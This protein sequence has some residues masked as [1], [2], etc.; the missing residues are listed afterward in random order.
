[1]KQTLGIFFLFLWSLAAIA[2]ENSVTG[3]VTDAND[4]SP[5]P[6][7][8]VSIKGTTTGSVTSLDGVY[9]VTA[10]QGDVLVF[11]FIGMKTIEATVS[12][13]TLNAAMTSS[14]TDLDD[15]VV[16]GYGV[17]KKSLITGATSSVSA[18]EMT[19][20]TMRA[21]QALQGKAPGVSVTANSGSPGNG[22]KVRIR[23]AGSNGKADPLY[24]VDGMKTG[25]IN[26]LAPGDIESME[27]LK[28][29]ASSAIYGTEGANGVI[30]IKTK[31]GQKG[32]GRIDYNFQY[33]IQSMPKTMDMMNASQYASYM[34]EILDKDGNKLPGVPALTSNEGT[35]WLDEVGET[36]PMSSHHLSFSGGTDKSTYSI[37][38][39]YDSQ[40][41]IIGGDRANFERITT[42]VNLTQE[43][44]K[45]CEVGANVAYTNS[46]RS[47]I[48]EDDGFNG[49][50]N[51]AIQM[52][53]TTNPFYSSP[54]PYMQT[55]MTNGIQLSRDANGNYYGISDNG[56]V[57]GEV[58]NPLLFIQNMK[59]ETVDNKI[60]GSAYIKL[61]PFEG[62]SFTSRA[63]MDLAFQNYNTWNPSYYGNDRAK[64][65]NASTVTSN[66]QKWS[67]WLWENFASYSKKID[68]HS[69]TLMAGVSAQEYNYLNLNTSAGIMIQENDRYRYPDYVTSRAKD[70]VGGGRT[71][72]S[73]SSTFG[74][75]S[76]DFKNKYM[77]EA[78]MRQD[79]SSLFGPDNKYGY[80]PSFSAGWTFSEE[81]FWSSLGAINFAKLRVSWG[82]NGSI[83]NLGPDQYRAL[84][85]TQGVEYPDGNGVLQPGAELDL[86]ANPKL[87][88]EASEQIDLGLDLRALGGMIY[89]T[90]DAYRKVTKDLLTPASGAL[91]LGNDF[92]FAN[93]G[94]VT[95]SGLEFLIGVQDS[96]SDFTYD[97]NMNLTTLKNEVTDMAEG[98]TRLNGASLPTVGVITYM[99][100]G[101]PIYYYRGYKT[102]GINAT[103]GEPIIVDVNGDGVKDEK[104][105]T[106]I[107]SP[108]PDLMLGVNI[109]LGYKGFDFNM[110]GQGA[111][112]QENYIGFMRADNTSYNKLTKF[113][114]DRWTPSNTN[115]SMP[116]AGFAGN[117]FYNSD[118]MV[119]DASY[120]KIRQIQLGYTLPKKISQKALL[121]KAR[122]YASLND[123]FTFTNY[124]GLDPEVGSGNNNA[125][126]VD[127]GIYPV[128]K[129]V[130]F[131]LNITF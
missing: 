124:S 114:E 41:G 112:G 119:E 88:W 6:G 55:L 68:D 131:G 14:T 25:D 113:Y 43:V 75:L 79:G 4:G 123:Y 58:Y 35:N 52:D 11:T 3:T 57:S 45:W 69:F 19:S 31:S 105:R 78:T 80:F 1:M 81:D 7:V 16:V 121:V 59:G 76:Y 96:K 89:F 110:F 20:S 46:K 13:S 37:S 61:M 91:S 84:I 129:K 128:S 51:S 72:T 118:L 104:D 40:D 127:F 28:D 21:E 23:G 53:P 2:Q 8:S 66:D 106:N 67:T 30:I 27:V 90:F 49:V 50:V 120:F 97:V 111:F 94:E 85:T 22:I 126:G 54:T 92:P 83:S 116:K 9:S 62:F 36:A 107:G 38:G 24:I 130:L 102:S 47:S 122:V 64:S 56:F 17:K 65:Q 42:R 32:D 63:G 18:K 39:G 117:T 125:Q 98:T 95:N 70:I 5:I 73:M 60:L 10:N 109:N 115:A 103:T 99:E 108:H 12:G 93:A 44:K 34:N 26:Y 29:A 33:G 77:L 74:R 48:T 101:Q 71:N 15:V 86:I 100:E 82:Q 87:K